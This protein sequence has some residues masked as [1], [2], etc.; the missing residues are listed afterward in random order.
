[1]RLNHAHTAAVSRIHT[2]TG[3]IT[4]NTAIKSMKKGPKLNKNNR[5]IKKNR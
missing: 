1:M 3:T 2:A 5:K 4:G